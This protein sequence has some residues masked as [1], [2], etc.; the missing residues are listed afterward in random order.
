MTPCPYFMLLL[1]V[2]MHFLGHLLVI[3]LQHYC[4]VITEFLGH[5]RQLLLL[6]FFVIFI[7]KTLVEWSFV[8]LFAEPI[9]FCSEHFIVVKL[10]YSH[11]HP[12]HDTFYS[13]EFGHLNTNS[14]VFML[15]QAIFFSG[16]LL[17]DLIMNC[18]SGL[19]WWFTFKTELTQDLRK[20]RFFSG[21]LLVLLEL[22][23]ENCICEFAEEAL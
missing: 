2:S 4:Q 22:K 1:K 16:S 8:V 19:C 20:F 12:L 18:N 21:K 13:S 15:A 3:Q 17:V 14:G 9:V 6:C 11:L 7:Q 23:V 5:I 10:V